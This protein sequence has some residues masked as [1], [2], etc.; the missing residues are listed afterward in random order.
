MRVVATDLHRLHNPV[1]ELEL[2]N[3][4]PPYECVERAEEINR[5]LRADDRFV[6]HSPSEWG[7]APIEAVHDP[8]LV[9][10]LSTAW[11]EYQ[12]I[13]GPSRE[14]IPDMFYKAALRDGM[15]PARRPSSIHGRL[16]W[17][18]FETTTPLVEGTYAA[19]RG[20]VD[21]AMTATRLVLNGDPV[22]YGLCRPPGHHAPKA[23]YGGYCFFNNAAVAANYVAS[24]TGTK[25]AILDVDYHHGN[26]IQQIFYDRDDVLYVSL[27]GDPAR[28][29]PYSIGFADERGAGRG[30]GHNLNIPLAARTGDDDYLKALDR[31]CAA[32][33]GFDP[34]MLI[35]SLGLDTFESDP[36]ADLA[37]TTDGFE[38]CGARVRELGLPTVVLQEGGYNVAALGENARR[39]LIGVGDL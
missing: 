35:V 6:F 8:D 31:A 1:L 22:V 26:G 3:F 14:V 11:A 4:H 27:H 38:R 21:T 9:R 29:Y 7:T 15:E 23:A 24:T 30:L 13:S 12:Q 2:S 39:W 28:A 36:I 16:G 10:F 17:W 34:S 5:V 25:V 18:C 19:A 37:L 33:A 20:S 32:I